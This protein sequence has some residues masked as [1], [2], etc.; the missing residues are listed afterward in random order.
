MLDILAIVLIIL[1]GGGGFALLAADAELNV[2]RWWFL[3]EWGPRGYVRN[4]IQLSWLDGDDRYWG[5][6]EI[7][8]DGPWP[9]FGFWFFHFSWGFSWG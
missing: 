9:S 6:Q 5:Y 1:G 2:G 8:Y 4:Y 3:L 7:W